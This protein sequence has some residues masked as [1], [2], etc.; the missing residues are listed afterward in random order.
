[1]SAVVGTPAQPAATAA[2]DAAATAATPAAPAAGAPAATDATQAPAATE[3]EANEDLSALSPAELLAKLNMWKAM[4]RKNEDKA[5]SLAEKAK[6]FDELEDAKKTELQKAQEENERLRLELATEKGGTLKADIAKAKG[7]PADLLV[8]ETKEALEAH[9]DTLLAF[10]GVTAPP[11]QDAA[12]SA[13]TG[14]PVGTGTG[15]L[16]R[17][18]VNAMSLA[19]IR[20][21][22]KAGLLNTLQGITE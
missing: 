16:T 2:T 18:Q 7:V 12:A 15:Q 20:E 4:S 22:K 11:A 6:Q 9:A 3:T 1:M 14:T 17:E 5:K 19:E 8:G 13:A 10:K 21:A